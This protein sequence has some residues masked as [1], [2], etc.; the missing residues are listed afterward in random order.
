MKSDMNKF[1][2]RQIGMCGSVCGAGTYTCVGVCVVRIN[3]CMDA[4]EMPVC[5][6]NNYYFYY[7]YIA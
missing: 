1:V 4:R 5:I 2:F 3:V 6:N 7:Y